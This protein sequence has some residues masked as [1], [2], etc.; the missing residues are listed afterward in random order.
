[1]H[2][3]IEVGPGEL[4]RADHAGEFATHQSDVGGLDGDI[5]PGADGD[6]NVGLGQGW[7][8]INAVADHGYQS[9]RNLL[10]PP[11][12][13]QFILGQHLGQHAVYA[14]LTGDGLRCALVGAC[15]AG[16]VSFL[17]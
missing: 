16:M 13:D 2:H 11:H 3:F 14:H 4:D 8:V 17:F 9:V 15:V 7:G 10:Q 1:M 6:T 5:R 12:L